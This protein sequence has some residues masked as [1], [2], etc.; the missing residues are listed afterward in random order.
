MSS[1]SEARR[2]IE[3]NG[4]RIN[5]KIVSD[6]KKIIKLSDFKGK[7]LKISHGKKKHYLVKLI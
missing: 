2:A 1:K 5:N 7:I 4:V 3:N 6:T